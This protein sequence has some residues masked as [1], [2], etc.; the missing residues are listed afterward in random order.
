[1]EPFELLAKKY[2]ITAFG[3]KTSF[4]DKF[5]FPTIK[6]WSPVDVPDF[7]YKMQI[8][9]RMFIDS[10]YLLGLEEK[11][12]DFD[13]A[14]TSETYFNYTRQCLNAKSRGY[15][16][17]VVVSVLENIPFN[18]EGIWGRKYFK[19]R[20]INETDH[21]IAASL[22]AKNALLKEGVSENKISVI[23]LSVNT[24]KFFPSPDYEKRQN[25]DAVNMLFAGRLEE[26]KGIFDLL[27]AF[28][29]IH[30]KNN[31]KLKLKLTV[32]GGG[33]KKKN[34]L[35]LEEKL[36]IQKVVNHRI[37]KYESMPDE[38]RKADF[39]IGPSK[40]DKYWKE[41]FGMV[42]AEAMAS[43]IPIISTNSGAIP[44]VV[45]DAGI[46][47]KTGSIDEIEN[48]IKVFLE[49]PQKRIWFSKIARKRALSKLSNEV[50]AKKLDLLYKSLL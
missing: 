13:I 2:S 41:Q 25:T 31:G 22:G 33:S 32:I 43:G 20:A 30:K 4:A 34:A 12:R 50:A 11:L 1:M 44:E 7:P 28:A 24:L 40:E 35:E 8:L 3:S 21:F 38:Y 45:G 9:N 16:K 49:S 36:G 23:N 14:H 42:F 5:L 26:Y 29:S 27:H 18:N 19:K 6:L 17:K 10:H 48:A 15:V 39:F 37:V 47:V 46:L